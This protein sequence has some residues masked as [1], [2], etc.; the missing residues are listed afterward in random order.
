MVHFPALRNLQILSMGRNQLKR[1]QGLEEIGQTLKE[2]WL[3]YNQIEKLEGLQ[4]CI[5]LET[6]YI[7]QNKIRLWDEVSRLA[8][9]PAIRNL[10][11]VGNPVYEDQLIDLRVQVVRRCPQLEVLDTHLISEQTRR[12]AEAAKLDKD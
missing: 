7:A 4:P 5:H 9:L 12:E 10:L 6:L 3:S 2:L 8:Q 1:I 11:L